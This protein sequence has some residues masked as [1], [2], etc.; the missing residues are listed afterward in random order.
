MFKDRSSGKLSLDDYLRKGVFCLN[1]PKYTD[2][3]GSLIVDK[4]VRYENL[5]DELAEVFERINVP[6]SGSL[7]VKAKS[8]H[9]IERLPY[10]SVLNEKQRQLITDVFSKE[11]EMHGYTY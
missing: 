10:N 11:I 1:Y 3:N 4:V 5:L 9:R 7:G 2:M 8:E 6:F